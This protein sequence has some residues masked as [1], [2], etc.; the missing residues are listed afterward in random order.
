MVKSP[1]QM[2]SP[3]E[4]AQFWATLALKHTQGIGPRTMVR[5]LRCFGSA[6]AAFENKNSWHEAGVSREKSH[7]LDTGSW[8]GTALQEWHRAQ[9]SDAHILMWHHAAYPSSLRS[10]ID[11]PALLYYAG[12][13][14]LLSMPCFAIVGSR[15]CSAE[16]VRVAADMAR[17]L[18]QAGISIVS[19]VAEGIDRV[20]HV[21]ALAHVG[22]SI[23]VLG[24]GIDVVYPQSNEDV[25]DKLRQE[26]LLLSEFAPHARP[27]AANFPIRNRIVSGAC[28]GVLV[29]EGMLS[30]GS[31]ITARL[32]LEQNREVYAIP[33]PTTAKLSKGC[34]ELI[35]QG[36]KP[37]FTSEDILQ[38]LALS[39]QS[40]IPL[41]QEIIITSAQQGAMT[42]ET[43][44]EKAHGELEG[45]APD[46]GQKSRESFA[47][48]DEFSAEDREVVRDVLL[49]LHAHG[50][51]H[52]DILCGV[53]Q[54]PISYTIAL[55]TEMELVELVKKMPGARYVA[56][57]ASYE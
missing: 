25:F 5:L 27:L 36:A 57:R 22:K 7:L 50:D 13:V 56:L 34:Q 44:Q 55:L 48:E 46:V 17:Q 15:K 29:V 43:I 9:M 52:I 53:T 38:D 19:G 16:G 37:V 23:G 14:S 35:R 10:L 3:A 1:W 45:I 2:L 40:F 28:L 4:R 47:P 32:A 51:V 8:R 39:L 30:S 24:S 20:A 12:D 41:R 54:R 31:L 26:G 49:Y 11:A 21:A 33:G 42:T 18:S 6:Y